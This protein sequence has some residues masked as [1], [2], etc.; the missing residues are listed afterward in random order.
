MSKNLYSKI[1]FFSYFHQH[2]D[3][4]LNIRVAWDKSFTIHNLPKCL[5]FF[6]ISRFIYRVFLSSAKRIV[7][8]PGFPIMFCSVKVINKYLFYSH[9]CLGKSWTTPIWLFNI[10]SQSKF[11]KGVSIFEK[12][13]I[14]FRSPLQFYYCRLS[15]NRIGRPMENL[16]CSY[17]SS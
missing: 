10:F 1:K 14:C 5:K 17:S 3:F 8:S 7:F 12:H 13:I 2:I 9:S 4:T 6:I 11:Y 16:N 15:S